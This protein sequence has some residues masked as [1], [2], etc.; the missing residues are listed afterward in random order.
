VP[1]VP[2]STVSTK[3]SSDIEQVTSLLALV[4]GEA[5]PIHVMW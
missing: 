4:D 1:C 3:N 5:I 2:A